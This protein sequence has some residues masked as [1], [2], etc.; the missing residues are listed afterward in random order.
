MCDREQ[1]ALRRDETRKSNQSRKGQAKVVLKQLGSFRA[2]TDC[3]IWLFFHSPIV[4]F[5]E[6]LLPSSGGLFKSLMEV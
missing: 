4:C 6:K 1:N 5:L 3:P 2:F